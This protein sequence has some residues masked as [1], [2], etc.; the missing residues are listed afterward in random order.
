MVHVSSCLSSI[1]KNILYVF[2]V[3]FGD[4]SIKN[5]FVAN[6][7]V[8]VFTYLELIQVIVDFIYYAPASAI[9]LIW[10]QSPRAG[11]YC[12]QA[13]L[14]INDVHNGWIVTVSSSHS[15]CMTIMV[16]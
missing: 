1:V 15:T 16:T 4:D 3:A 11:A 5:Y 6:S 13:C 2:C 14:V 8:G 10:S 12:K 9:W 7:S